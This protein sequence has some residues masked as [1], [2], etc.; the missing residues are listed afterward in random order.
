MALVVCIFVSSVLIF[1]LWFMFSLSNHI[2]SHWEFNRF[3]HSHIREGIF[4]I[5]NLIISKKKYF[6]LLVINILCHCL[7]GMKKICFLCNLILTFSEKKNRVNRDETASH[8]PTPSIESNKVPNQVNK[9]RFL[10]WIYNL[11]FVF[12]PFTF[13]QGPNRANQT[14]DWE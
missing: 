5:L 7:W 1:I 3:I 10:F 12:N 8:S 4:Y 9:K 2:L 14:R 6:Y 11:Q 13:F